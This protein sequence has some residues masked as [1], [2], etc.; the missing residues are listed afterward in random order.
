MWARDLP[1]SINFSL[2]CGSWFR[3]TIAGNQPA[4]NF[5]TPAG[6]FAP[7][8]PASLPWVKQEKLVGFGTR[9]FVSACYVRISI[10][11]RLDSLPDKP[12]SRQWN[13]RLHAA[14]AIG[15]LR[16]ETMPK[17]ILKTELQVY[18]QRLQVYISPKNVTSFFSAGR[19]NPSDKIAH[20]HG[21]W[22]LC[23]YRMKGFD[24]LN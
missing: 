19:S 10:S 18:V 17:W 11:E 1:L 16:P 4:R 6:Q 8:P 3:Q 23:S 7:Q 20:P 21:Q 9:V 5:L 12:S 22:A 24:N 15:P 2:S 13:D 14:V